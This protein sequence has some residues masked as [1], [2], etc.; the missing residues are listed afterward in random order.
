MPP[1]PFAARI[2]GR[3][4]L[5]PMSR[6]VP[7]QPPRPNLVND[8]VHIKPTNVLANRQG[9]V[10]LCDFGL[11]G[12]IVSE[13]QSWLSEHL[14]VSRLPTRILMFGCVS[15]VEIAVGHYLYTHD[16]DVCST[17]GHYR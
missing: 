8:F 10:K 15:L 12:E 6:T 13:N 4:V 17:Q 9:K 1:R 16:H 7:L 3:S 11:L 14:S 5:P 2:P